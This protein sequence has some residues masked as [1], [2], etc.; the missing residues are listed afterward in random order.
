MI[1]LLSL[2]LL[3]AVSVKIDHTLAETVRWTY[4]IVPCVFTQWFS[5]RMHSLGMDRWFNPFVVGV[6]SVSVSR[7][8]NLTFASDGQWSNIRYKM[9]PIRS[10]V[11]ELI[12]CA[13]SGLMLS[14]ICIMITAA[15]LEVTG[16]RTPE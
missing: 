3:V 10:G 15:V 13:S 16:P 12:L 4:F 1:E 5:F 6:G 7:L 14:F 11:D 8:A 9:F 2:T